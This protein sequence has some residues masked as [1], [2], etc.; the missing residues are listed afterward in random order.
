MDRI[1]TLRFTSS[2]CGL[3]L[4]NSGIKKREWGF[5]AEH[6]HLIDN[7]FT[8]LI[9]DDQKIEGVEVVKYK[10]LI[11]GIR[12][13]TFRV[14]ENFDI[15]EILDDYID[16]AL[17][18]IANRVFKA[19]IV[20][21]KRTLDYGFGLRGKVIKFRVV[22]TSRSDFMKVIQDY[23]LGVTAE[24]YKKIIEKAEKIFEQKVQKAKK[25]KTLKHIRKTRESYKIAL[26]EIRA[27]AKKI[28][29]K[30]SAA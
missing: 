13:V 10:T 11:A 20:A 22:H 19:K 21:E 2:E 14:D 12:E 30:R 26:A 24:Q 9:F 18:K 15:V 29:K 23:F 25:L 1:V 4:M 28:F 3:T 17:Q 6:R 5:L 7:M 8:A 16:G 27:K